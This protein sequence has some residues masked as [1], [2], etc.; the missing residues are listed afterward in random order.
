MDHDM[1]IKFGDV[2][3]SEEKKPMIQEVGV[4]QRRRGAM[5]SLQSK[6]IK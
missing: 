4:G 2:G 3:G 1:S 6:A 5:M